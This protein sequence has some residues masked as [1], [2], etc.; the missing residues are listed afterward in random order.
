MSAGDRRD[1][2]SPVRLTL[3]AILGDHLD[4]AW[5]PYTASVARELPH[6]IE[7]VSSRLGDIVDIS[8]NWSSLEGAPTLNPLPYGGKSA[9][10]GQQIRQQRIITIVGQESRVNLLV[11]PAR[12]GRALA[13]MVLRHAASLPILPRHVDTPAYRAAEEIVSTARTEIAQRAATKSGKA[14]VAD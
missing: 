1:N 11:I 3:A 7:A 8:V 6:L 10:P 14:S 2:S 5:W 12:T 4:G 9:L 13:V